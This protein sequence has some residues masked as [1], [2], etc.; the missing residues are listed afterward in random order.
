MCGTRQ[1]QETCVA[2]GAMQPAPFDQAICRTKRGNR[3]ILAG[4]RVAHQH[5]D[6]SCPHFDHCTWGERRLSLLSS[7][8]PSHF[9]NCPV[10]PWTQWQVQQSYLESPLVH[11]Q[12]TACATVTRTARK[13]TGRLWMRLPALPYRSRLVS[14][15]EFKHMAE[16]RRARGGGR[17]RDGQEWQTEPR[18]SC[19]GD[20]HAS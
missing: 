20:H 18:C 2:C 17:I 5:A 16:G 8:H 10:G 19:P 15:W 11:I 1:S 6:G 4:N 14:F 9:G 12:W 7:A 3:R 13:S